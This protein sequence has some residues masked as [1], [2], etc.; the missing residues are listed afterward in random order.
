MIYDYFRVTS[1]MK[2]YKDSQTCWLSFQNDDVQDFDFRWDHALL[3]VSEMPSDVILEGLYK[4]KLQNSAQLQTVL[5]I[6]YQKTARNTGMTNYQQLKTAVKLH[7]NQMILTRHLRV[8]IDIVERGSVIKSQKGK[9]AFVDRKVEEC[10]QWKAHGQCSKGDSCSFR[11]DIKTS[12]NSG[13]DQSSKGRS[14]SP[15]PNSKAKQFDD[16]ISDK[17]ESSDKRIQIVCRNRNCK[18][19]SCK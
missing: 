10:S 12:G 3:P 6:F 15:A 16:E 9:K 2:Q 4:S 11:H 8:W 13:G 5:A 1:I 19:P 17:E 14:S 18:N 7:M